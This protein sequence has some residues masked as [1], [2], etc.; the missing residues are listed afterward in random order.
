MYG[1]FAT[2]AKR[3]SQRKKS[4]RS[5]SLKLGIRF[6][7]SQR[8]S[9]SQRSFETIDKYVGRNADES[10]LKTLLQKFFT[11]RGGLRSEVI[12]DVM[13]NVS[14]IRQTL[15]DLPEY[16]FYSSS[17]LI[18]YEGEPEHVTRYE[19]DKTD[20][21]MDCEQ[22]D[23]AISADNNKVIVK[24]IEFNYSIFLFSCH[25]VTVTCYS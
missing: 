6:C 8:F 23:Q 16:R 24:Q 9:S 4:K 20:N 19:E 7:G 18:I 21:S 17:L 5:T 13:K 3:K 25:L 14:Q 12:C 15:I 22:F 11:C 10:E 1:D 2:E